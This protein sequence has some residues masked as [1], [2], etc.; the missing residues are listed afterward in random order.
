MMR[1]KLFDEATLGQA[2]TLIPDSL[3]LK[4]GEL[5]GERGMKVDG[6]LTNVKLVSTDDSPIH[7]SPTAKLLNCVI[8][9]KDV[10]IE[11]HYEGRIDAHGKVEFGAGS[12]VM[13]TCVKGEDNEI[14]AHPLS[15]LDDLRFSKRFATAKPSSDAAEL[16]TG[17]HGH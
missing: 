2:R 16:S 9:G 15:D 5:S 14:Y 1:T 4:G 6:Q 8:D 3:V 17:T 12:T 10:F 7:I 11:G 13:G